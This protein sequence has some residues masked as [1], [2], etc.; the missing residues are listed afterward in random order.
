MDL[1]ERVRRLERR[2]H[3]LTGVVNASNMTLATLV[4]IIGSNPSIDKRQ[5]FAVIETQLKIPLVRKV[6]SAISPEE[7]EAIIDETREGVAV[8]LS[9]IR[10]R[11]QLD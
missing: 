5:L 8:I 4:S 9:L 3:T 11:L 2:T 6:T 10:E 1:E 7:S